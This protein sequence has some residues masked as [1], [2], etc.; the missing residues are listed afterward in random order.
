[1]GAQVAR[2]LAAAHAAGV[3]HRDVKPA[4]VV[5]TP[6]GAKVVDFGLAF[7]HRTAEGALL[8]TPAYVAPELL[9]GEDPTPAADVYALGVLLRET[10]P[11]PV[12]SGLAALVD[13]CLDADPA[14]RPTA[15]ETAGTLEPATP[16][17]HGPAGPPP[18]R[19]PAPDPEAGNPTRILDDPLPPAP[20]DASPRRTPLLVSG[21]ASPRRSP[22]SASGGVSARRPL[23]I[24]GGV[25]AAL[26]LVLLLVAALSDERRPAASPA[27][28]GRPSSAAHAPT[29]SPS[30]PP[31]TPAEAAC[32]VAYAVTGQWPGGFQAQVRITNLGASAVDGWRLR[33]RFARGE[34]ITQ[35]WN[36]VR[37][38]S[39]ADV[40]V[41]AADYNRRI[42][43][44]G[45]AEFGFLGTASGSAPEPRPDAFAL[46]G[47]PC[48]QA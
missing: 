20:E 46:G 2:A 39:G 9:A 30:T 31:S 17:Q 23:L 32:A 40:T 6:A 18:A 16:P 19:P 8:G 11:E 41:T 47:T 34:R 10:L 27:P 43:P 28:T 25:A 33:W 44:H 26:L 4:N 5:L 22:S 1:M 21:G 29:T 15:A 14:R 42:A 13:R 7:G 38:Q 37:E 3:V 12:P 24:G 35:I 48:D 45:T 36:G